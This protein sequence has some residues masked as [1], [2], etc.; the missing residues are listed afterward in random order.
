M[1][2]GSILTLLGIGVVAGGIATAVAVL[3]P[4]LPS[5]ASREAG[6]IDF[7]FWFV[8][9]ICILIFAVVAAALLYSV[10]RFR[11][12]P[13]DLSDGPPIHGHTGL[14]IAWTLVPTLLVTAI[15]IVSAVVLAQNDAQG[16]NVLNVDVTAQQF[17]WTFSYPGTHV[18]TA[19][20][21]VPLGR[22]VL[23][24]L[25]A[26]DV[27]HSFWVAEW[28]QKEDTVPGL[29]TTLHVT[30]DKLGSFPIICTELCGLGHALMRSQAVVMEPAA[31]DAWLKKQEQ[32]AAAAE[33]S[34]G[35]GSASGSGGAGN[36]QAVF[37]GNACGSCHTLSA[38]GAS[39]NVGPDLDR[40]P[41]Y[42]Q[43]AGQPLAAFVKQSIVDPN[44]YVEKGYPQ[45][46]MPGT[47]G[48]S[49]S[50]QQLDSLVQYLVQSSQKG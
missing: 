50:P 5:P 7:V 36:G 1:R 22:S 44:A 14:E 6:R 39:G 9:A 23:L 47:F 21:R 45:G 35:S 2:R 3:L 48:K 42:A 40:L 37:Q 20:L 15:G 17:A 12:A 38:A 16:K 41:A 18:T 34:S 4:W 31:F 13:D 19:T 32:A 43:K 28:S 11:A 33:S 27:I 46:V 10:V 26:K 25:H 30:P 49:L 29:T 8:I 24:T